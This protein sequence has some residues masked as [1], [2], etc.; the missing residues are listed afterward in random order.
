[1]A[2]EQEPA[3]PVAVVAPTEHPHPAA[4]DVD[5]ASREGSKQRAIVRYENTGSL[6][7]FKLLLQPHA[8]VQ[9]EV[10][11]GFVQ[12]KQRAAETRWSGLTEP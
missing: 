3:L 6:P 2:F 5:D 8:S 10:I 12:Q 4:L 9:V 1:V 7:Q 11:R